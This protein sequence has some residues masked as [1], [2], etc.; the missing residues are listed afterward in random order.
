MT[1]SEVC[2]A[3]TTK[4]RPFYYA[5]SVH[6]SAPHHHQT[7][8]SIPAFTSLCTTPLASP[9]LSFTTLGSHPP[10]ALFHEN[11]VSDVPVTPL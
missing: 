2:L 5:L 9:W 10:R 4:D 3:T 11:F 7:I 1:S 8:F 6:V